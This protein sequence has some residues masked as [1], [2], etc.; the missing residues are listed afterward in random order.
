MYCARRSILFNQIY[1]NTYR[2]RGGEYVINA[3]ASNASI[4]P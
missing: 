4:Y 3:M 1:I 2:T